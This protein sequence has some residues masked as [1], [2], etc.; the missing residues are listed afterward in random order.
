MELVGCQRVVARESLAERID[1]LGAD[2][3]KHHPD[4]SERQFIKRTLGMAVRGVL[5]RLGFGGSSC[6]DAHSLR[7]RLDRLRLC[8]PWAASEIL[9]TGALH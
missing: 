3:A 5:R 8:I 4:R 6:G 9:V 2:V 7:F 1:R